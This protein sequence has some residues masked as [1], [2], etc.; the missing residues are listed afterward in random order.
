MADLIDAIV[1]AQ[2]GDYE[3]V[4]GMQDSGP[5]MGV[6]HVPIDEY[7]ASPRVSASKLRTFMRL[8]PRAYYLR[9]VL[10]TNS[11]K[12][13]K[14]MIVGQAFEDAVC[15]KDTFVII[16]GDGRTKAVKQQKAAAEAEGKLVLG[17]E[18][19]DF[20]KYGLQNLRENRAATALIKNA[21]EQPT[22][23]ADF[24]GLSGIQA[25]PDWGHASGTFP[26]LKTTSTLEKFS[27]SVVDFG[28]HIQAA[29]VR[30]CAKAQGIPSTVHRLIVVERE[31]PYRCQVMTL[32][33]E[34]LELGEE[35]AERELTRLAQCYRNEDWF[36]CEEH[37]VL[38]PPRWLLEKVQ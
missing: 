12:R 31:W 14:P 17:G 3:R 2:A 11:I 9:H 24:A 16:E 38:E 8:G 10:K 13:S 4:R 21:E 22:L 35:T 29:L 5:V 25:R 32:S 33:D 20:M 27:R 23:Y 1:T 18:S 34:Y 30:M 36:S 28:Y 7:H 15:G 26:D 19:A 6:D 37:V